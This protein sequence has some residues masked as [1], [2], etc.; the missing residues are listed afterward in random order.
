LA[1]ATSLVGV[2]G[3][4]KMD[5]FTEGSVLHT[6]RMRYTA[7]SIYTSVGS[8]LIAVNSYRHLPDLYAESVM[9]A[10]AAEKTNAG[11]APHPFFLMELAYRGLIADRTSQSILICKWF[12]LTHYAELCIRCVGTRMLLMLIRLHKDLQY[13]AYVCMVDTAQRVLL[14]LAKAVQAN[15]DYKVLAAVLVTPQQMQHWR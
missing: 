5:A 8:I 14:Q 7:G 15:R 10:Y 11:P 2:D 13:I 6:L 12:T 3:M 1:D 4:V 9:E